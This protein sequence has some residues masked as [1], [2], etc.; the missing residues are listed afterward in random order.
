VAVVESGFVTQIGITMLTIS[1]RCKVQDDAA[2]K[3]WFYAQLATAL[4]PGHPERQRRFAERLDSPRRLI[5]CVEP[6]K[7]LSFDSAKMG[8]HFR[9]GE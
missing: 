4:I 9:G 8:G 7:F 1:G 6:E 3:R 2:T 5:L